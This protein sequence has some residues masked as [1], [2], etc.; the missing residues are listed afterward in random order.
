MN[1]FQRILGFFRPSESPTAP[2]AAPRPVTWEGD[3]DAAPRELR[4]KLMGTALGIAPELFGD[5][6]RVSPSKALALDTVWRA[7]SL[8]S[9]LVAGI[10]IKHYRRVTNEGRSGRLER[11]SRVA[12]ILRDGP[13][14][15]SGLTGHTMWQRIML[16]VL[17]RSGNSYWLLVRNPGG[18]LTG[19]R[20]LPN[21]RAE[22]DD[23]GSLRYRIWAGDRE[24]FRGPEDI[25][26]FRGLGDDDNAFNPIDYQSKVLG[27]GGDVLDFA[28]SYFQNGASAR[29]AI[30]IPDEIGPEASDRLAKN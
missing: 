16:D 6:Y 29:L 1:W 27:L 21:C 30:E 8:I 19:I 3:L 4:H 24:F 23:S 13:G 20:Y 26:H 5:L 10:P 15:D 12:R 7:V 11:Q 2:A 28:S 25:L 14:A 17:V 9:N 18:T 22:R